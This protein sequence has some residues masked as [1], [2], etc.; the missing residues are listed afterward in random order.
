MERM[1]TSCYIG[2][3]IFGNKKPCQINWQKAFVTFGDMR[4]Y[5]NHR[6]DPT[7]AMNA[8]RRQ[9]RRMAKCRYDRGSGSSGTGTSFTSWLPRQVLRCPKRADTASGRE[10]SG[11]LNDTMRL[12]G[13]VMAGSLGRIGL[14]I[15]HP[16]LQDV[17]EKGYLLDPA[18]RRCDLRSATSFVIHDIPWQ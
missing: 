1:A 4:A 7:P 13:A 10:R 15:P 3:I 8:R 12:K 9:E 17:A 18:R 6:S 2:I 14:W 16:A 11:V 5:R